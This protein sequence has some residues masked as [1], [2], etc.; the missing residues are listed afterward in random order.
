MGLNTAV[1]T[2][3]RF[4]TRGTIMARKIIGCTTHG[5]YQKCESCSLHENPQQCLE[6]KRKFNAEV[7][8]VVL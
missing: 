1:C 7:D 4:D 3:K 5:K 8:E 6:F 2:V